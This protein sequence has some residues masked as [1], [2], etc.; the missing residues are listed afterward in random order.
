MEVPALIYLLGLKTHTC[1]SQEAKKIE[2]LCCCPLPDLVPSIIIFSLSQRTEQSK[3]FRLVVEHT[4]GAN[5][6]IKSDEQD[7]FGYSLA[8]SVII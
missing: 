1:T 5:Q 8:R 3:T 4:G 6:S 7:E 2:S